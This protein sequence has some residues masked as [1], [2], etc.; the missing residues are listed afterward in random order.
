MELE[1]E[2]AKL[3]DLLRGKVVKAVVRHRSGEAVIEFEEGTR[4]FVNNI[5]DG[6]EF[7]VTG[8]RRASNGEDPYVASLTRATSLPPRV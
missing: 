5:P 1:V 8:G 2:A 7:S 4:L 6:L 3:T